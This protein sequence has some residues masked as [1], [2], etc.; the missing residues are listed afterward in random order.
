MAERFLVANEAEAIVRSTYDLA[1]QV[2]AETRADPSRLPDLARILIAPLRAHTE[3]L[4]QEALAD[5]PRLACRAGCDW[6]CRGTAV[7]VLAP[8]ILVIVDHLQG[9]GQEGWE[10]KIRDS[11]RRVQGMSAEERHREAIPCPLLEIDSGRCSVHPVRP[12]ACRGQGSLRARD[13]QYG[14]QHP[15]EDRPIPKHAALLM[16]QSAASMG[17]RLS[18]SEMDLDARILELTSALDVAISHRRAAERWARGE[19]LFGQ[20]I[21]PD[22]RRA[23]SVVGTIAGSAAGAPSRNQRKAARRQRRSQ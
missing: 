5:G 4:E 13:C 14:L 15:N 9:S 17:L 1:R 18:L 19:K 11:A 6:C 23:R 7:D 12:L 20:A 22:R 10:A 21:P 8:E 3:R 2:I 16:S